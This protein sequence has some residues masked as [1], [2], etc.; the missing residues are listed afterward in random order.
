MTLES[1]LLNVAFVLIVAGPVL[2]VI[3]RRVWRGEARFYG[4]WVS[5]AKIREME[6][7]RRQAE[8]DR[9]PPVSR[10]VG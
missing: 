7:A 4:F 10:D 6:K 5:P 1:K 2:A 9:T 3:V 8:Q